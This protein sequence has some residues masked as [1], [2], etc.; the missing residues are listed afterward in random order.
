MEQNRQIGGESLCIKC[1]YPKRVVFLNSMTLKYL[2]WTVRMWTDFDN[3][4]YKYL[5]VL[6]IAEKPY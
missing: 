3:S 2:K 6:F 4:F 5:T 1:N